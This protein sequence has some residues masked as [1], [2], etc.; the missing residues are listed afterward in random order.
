M[1]SVNLTADSSLYCIIHFVFH[2][3][4]LFLYFILCTCFIICPITFNKKHVYHVQWCSEKSPLTNLLVIE[5][6]PS[7]KNWK[8]FQQHFNS[9]N[10]H[11]S[12]RRA[13]FKNFPG[14]LFLLGSILYFSIGA[15]QTVRAEGS[16]LSQ[17]APV[18]V[19]YT[20]SYCSL[21]LAYYWYNQSI[22]NF[23]VIAWGGA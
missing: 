19:I 11:S 12:F 20:L 13:V 6:V 18:Y 21:L 1:S 10:C 17:T 22:L 5:L 23:R 15:P 3:Y 16:K 2:Y 4:Y 9:F 7:G 8:T 14:F